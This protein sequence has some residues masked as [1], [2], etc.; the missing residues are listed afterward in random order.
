MHTLRPD[1]SRLEIFLCEINRSRSRL[2]RKHSDV[3]QPP[4]PSL[5]CGRDERSQRSWAQVSGNSR[6]A[7]QEQLIFAAVIKS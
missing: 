3:R 5:Y 2:R 4:S 6:G 7:E 1:I